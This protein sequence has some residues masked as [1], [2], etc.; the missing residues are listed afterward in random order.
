MAL[1]ATKLNAS[2]KDHVYWTDRARRLALDRLIDPRDLERTEKV[3]TWP[4]SP[5]LFVFYPHSCEWRP[6]GMMATWA[7]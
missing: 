5:V 1:H 4:I 7:G 2:F 6:V 3:K